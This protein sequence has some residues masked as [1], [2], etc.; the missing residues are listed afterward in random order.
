[1]VFIVVFFFNYVLCNVIKC[2]IFFVFN[3]SFDIIVGVI[4][5]GYISLEVVVF[6][7]YYLRFFFY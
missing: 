7:E 4:G 6:W 2:I 3:M 5:W 1:M